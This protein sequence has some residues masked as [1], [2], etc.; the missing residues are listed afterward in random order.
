MDRQR[1]CCLHTHTNMAKEKQ[2][3]TVETSLA[4]WKKLSQ[5]KISK[6][7]KSLDQS[8]SYLFKAMTGGLVK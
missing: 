1:L 8:V 7:L 5:L 3:K 6:G 4:N 2:T